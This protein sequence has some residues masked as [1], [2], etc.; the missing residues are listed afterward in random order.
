MR[1]QVLRFRTADRYTIRA[2]ILL[3]G[4]D[5]GNGGTGLPA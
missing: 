1:I 2:T 3:D 5:R 4:F